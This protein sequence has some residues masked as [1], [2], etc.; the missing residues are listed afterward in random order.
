V[1][2]VPGPGRHPPTS[3]ARPEL[4]VETSTASASAD[5]FPGRDELAQTRA[6]DANASE[7]NMDVGP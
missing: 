2:V 6:K 7:D 3:P 5:S 1:T 4:R